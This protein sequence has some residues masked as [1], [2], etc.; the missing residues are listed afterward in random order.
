MEIAAAHSAVRQDSAVGNEIRYWSIAWLRAVLLDDC[1]A[2]PLFYADPF[3]L[4]VDADW[5]SADRNNL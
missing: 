1:D 3:A 4:T 2:Q 5:R